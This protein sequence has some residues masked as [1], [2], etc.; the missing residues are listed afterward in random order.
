MWWS[1]RETLRKPQNVSLHH[2]SSTVIGAIFKHS[3]PW[4]DSLW[5][6][7]AA[8]AKFHK[9]DVF[10]L[11]MFIL[12]W[13]WRLGICKED[14]GSVGSFWLLWARMCS[15]SLSSVEC[16]PA[17]FHISWLVAGLLQFL[18]LSKHVFS[19]YVSETWPKFLIRTLGIEFR[20]LSSITSS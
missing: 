20:A 10:K 11:P 9:L 16:L 12:S 18:T 2:F 19:L 17:I 3:L 15:I 4:R 14:F 6:W 7:F 13:F 1:C 5:L 8:V